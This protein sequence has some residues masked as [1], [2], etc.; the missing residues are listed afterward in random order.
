MFQSSLSSKVSLF[1]FSRKDTRYRS[2]G[3]ISPSSTFNKVSILVFKD[4]ATFIIN[5][6]PGL[7]FSSL[8]ILEIYP[9][10]TPASVSSSPIFF[11]DSFKRKEMLSNIIFLLNSSVISTHS[12]LLLFQY[13]IIILPIRQYVFMY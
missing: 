5:S 9:V 6:I 4:S 2:V 7:V 13:N 11:P 12:F 8:L 1:N 10:L 3:V